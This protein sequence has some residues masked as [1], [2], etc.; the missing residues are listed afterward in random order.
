[1]KV[2]SLSEA[3]AK[4]SKLVETVGII[5][6]GI[7]ITKNGRPA[8]IL[9]NPEEFEGWQETISIHSDEALMREIK[10]G[11]LALKKKRANLY[12]LE[13]LFE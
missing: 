11:L 8:A 10:E 12:T 4:L 3:K 6:E 1:M 13:E 5:N 9:V 2:L 7:M